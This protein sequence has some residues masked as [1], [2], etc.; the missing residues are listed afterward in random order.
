M[1]NKYHKDSTKKKL[2]WY[3]RYLGLFSNIKIFLESIRIVKEAVS[4]L[5]ACEKIFYGSSKTS[6]T[7][8]DTPSMSYFAVK[9]VISRKGTI[10]HTCFFF[11]SS[12]SPT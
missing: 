9:E 11:E 10:D 5:S 3:F 4:P 8:S 2:S 6:Q 1:T 12:G 7:Q